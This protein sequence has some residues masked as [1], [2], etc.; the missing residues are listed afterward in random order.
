M[1][2]VCSQLQ[3]ISASLRVV[4][5]FALKKQGSVVLFDTHVTKLLYS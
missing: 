4:V 2:A 1:N 5:G 3:H